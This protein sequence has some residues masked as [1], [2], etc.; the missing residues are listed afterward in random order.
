MSLVHGVDASLILRPLLVDAT[1]RS[2]V[3][4]TLT[5]G[6]ELVGDVQARELGYFNGA[7]QKQALGLGYYGVVR[8]AVDSGALPAGNSAYDSGQ[9]PAN[10]VWTV[11]NLAVRYTGTIA[12]VTLSVG[13]L[14]GVSL[15]VIDQWTITASGLFYGY[16][17]SLELAPGEQLRLT[18][19]G[20][21]AG[22]VA[23]LRVV[24]RTMLTNL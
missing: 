22:D 15:Y 1:G 5:A 4:A 24:G 20:A 6:T 12:G 19:T 7:W 14:V 18:V 13:V 2:L 16:P 11:E 17:C 3:T 8:V 23:S 10:T 9:V 21:T